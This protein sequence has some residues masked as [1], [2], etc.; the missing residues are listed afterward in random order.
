MSEPTAQPSREALR[1]AL[2]E[3]TV[4][5][6][7][8][9]D[10]WSEDAQVGWDEYVADAALALLPGRSE[11]AIKAEA[12]REAAELFDADFCGVSLTLRSRAAGLEALK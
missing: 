10:G 12:L 11:A 8:E 5:W 3:A 6:N 4:K 7:E 1:D 9:H 2:A